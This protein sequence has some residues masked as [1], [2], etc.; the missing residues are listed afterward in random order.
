MNL[1]SGKILQIS[2]MLRIWSGVFSPD[3]MGQFE[4]LLLA[5]QRADGREEQAFDIAVVEDGIPGR[6]S[7]HDGVL[8]GQQR[9]VLEG[10]LDQIL[11]ETAEEMAL[12]SQTDLRMLIEKDLHPRR[13]GFRHAAD[14]EHAFD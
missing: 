7:E 13:A 3:D 14:E 12:A 6:L 9:I 8:V 4:F 11:G 10:G 5:E 2:G 1:A